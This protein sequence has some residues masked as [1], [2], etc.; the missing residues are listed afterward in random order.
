[1]TVEGNTSP[2]GKDRNG[3]Q[4]M[5]K[6]R[7]LGNHSGIVGYGRPVYKSPNLEKETT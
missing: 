5:L 7:A 2:A 1:V 4:V 6:T 3:G